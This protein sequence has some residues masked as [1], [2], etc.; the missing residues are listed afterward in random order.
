MATN[1]QRP[2]LLAEEEDNLDDAPVFIRRN[3]PPG[4]QKNSRPSVQSELLDLQDDA[5]SKPE[6][7]SRTRDYYRHEREI[8]VAIFIVAFD[9]KKGLLIT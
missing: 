3:H 1:D 7:V 5:I 4:F 2:L 9:T 6:P 8:V